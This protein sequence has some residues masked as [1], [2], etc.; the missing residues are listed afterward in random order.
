MPWQENEWWNKPAFEVQQL[1]PLSKKHA[2]RWQCCVVTLCRYSHT[3][4][5]SLFSPRILQ[6]WWYFL[7]TGIMMFIE[8]QYYLS[9]YCDAW[10]IPLVVECCSRIVLRWICR[11]IKLSLSNELNYCCAVTDGLGGHRPYHEW[12]NLIISFHLSLRISSLR[13]QCVGQPVFIQ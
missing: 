4:R 12:G 9:S 10:F 6:D 5:S 3:G 11:L 7:R 13:L 2:C 8:K 1:R